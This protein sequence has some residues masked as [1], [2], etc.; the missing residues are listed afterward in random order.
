MAYL[1]LFSS[2]RNF[3]QFNQVSQATERRRMDDGHHNLIRTFFILQN[4]RGPSFLLMHAVQKGNNFILTFCK[5]GHFLTPVYRQ[6]CAKI[7][8]RI[9][10]RSFKVMPISRLVESQT[11][12]VLKELIFRQNHFLGRE[13]GAQF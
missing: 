7:E 10:R 9:K 8:R 6:L 13:K 11:E 5:T 12:E 2:V 1:L 3:G 4:M